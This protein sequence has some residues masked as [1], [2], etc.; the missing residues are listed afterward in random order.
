MAGTLAVGKQLLE[1]MGETVL[2]PESCNRFKNGT[3]RMSLA[4]FA[5]FFA[6]WDVI[7]V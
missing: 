6:K 1:E 4:P 5:F 7:T 3:C 2:M